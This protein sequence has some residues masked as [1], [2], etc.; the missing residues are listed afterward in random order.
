MTPG[1][2]FDMYV[3]YSYYYIYV[4]FMYRQIKI[5]ILNVLRIHNQTKSLMTV[6]NGE[7]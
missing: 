3:Y 5:I 2:S 4:D 6:T 7:F 1:H